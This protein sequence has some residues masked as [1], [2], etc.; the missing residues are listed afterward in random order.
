MCICIWSCLNVGK[1]HNDFEKKHNVARSLEV[2]GGYLPNNAI[3]KRATRASYKKRE[4]AEDDDGMS[5]VC[6]PSNNETPGYVHDVKC[7]NEKRRRKK[8]RPR[9]SLK[10]TPCVN[11]MTII[12]MMMMLQ[13]KIPKNVQSRPYVSLYCRHRFSLLKSNKRWS[14]KD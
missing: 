9:R 1:N 5:P 11:P 2:A 10:Q 12:M 6:A 7:P 3:L 13:T 4:N 14:T 8:T